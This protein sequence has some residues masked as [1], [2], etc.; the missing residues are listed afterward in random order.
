MSDIRAIVALSELEAADFFP[1]P[2]WGELERLLPG[3]RRVQLPLSRPEDWV[4]LWRET[5]A[6]LLVS[7][8]QTPPL[9]GPLEPDDV[10]S[11]RYVCYLA[12]SVRKLVPRELVDRGLIVTNWGNTIAATVA[13]CALMLILMALRRAS[14]WALAMHREG[15]WKNGAP[16][17][18]SLLGRRVGLHGFGAISQ[19][20]VP[21]LVPF[22]DQIQT[23]SPH[24][25]DD[26]L[27][28]RKVRRAT[29]LEELFSTSDIVVELAA[30]T[31]QNLHIVKESHL[32]SIPAGGVFVNVGRGCVVDEAA[33]L[34]VAREGNLQIALD[35][36]E[37]EPLPPDSPFR[38]LP[39]VTLLPHLGGP[40]RDRRRDSGA[41][42]LKNIRAFLKGDPQ[43]AVI[44]LDTYDRST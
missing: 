23:Y 3:Y 35:V 5:P 41:L 20:L 13:E 32:R 37:Q 24:V 7:A 42:A 36:Y 31:P 30:A 39:N 16:T 33:L 18:Q 17:T 6:E 25:P 44:N 21:M 19:Q 1:G 27:A 29:S 38:G 15:A 2:M 28:R 43:E 40:T 12:G 34:R 26:I 9:N 11:L 22:T 10:K 4:R 8:W 14:Y